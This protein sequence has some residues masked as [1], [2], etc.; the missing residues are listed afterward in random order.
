MLEIK[1]VRQDE[2]DKIHYFYHCLI[3]K[4]NTK[5]KEPKVF[6]GDQALS[7]EIRKGNIYV[8]ISLNRIISIMILEHADSRS[9]HVK[10]FEMSSQNVPRYMRW[11]LIRIIQDMV[12]LIR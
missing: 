11:A 3:E 10:N 9:F 4:I 6:L 5:G 12:C 1:R 8:G 7:K 2:E